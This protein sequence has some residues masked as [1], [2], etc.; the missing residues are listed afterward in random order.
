MSFSVHVDVR[1]PGQFFACCGL[2]ELA[3]RMSEG[4][5]AHFET[6]RFIVEA[7]CSL[8]ELLDGLTGSPLAEVDQEDSTASPIGLPEVFGLRLDWWKDAGGGGR[9]LKVWAGTMQSLRIAQAMVTALREPTFHSENLL[10]VGC[11]VYDPA[12]RTKKVEPFYFD[13]RR[14]PNAHSRDVGFSPNDLGLTTTA[15]PA[16]EALCLVGLQRCRPAPQRDEQRRVFRYSVWQ[17]P[18][19]VT[20]LAAVVSGTVPTRGSRTFE[21][22]NWYRT[23]QRKHK[24]FRYAVPFTKGE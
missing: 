15:F 5:V 14:T 2:F 18:L 16:V 10:D 23:G 6:E 13:A 1:N 7:A 11:V 8:D 9:E 21:F 19:P 4:A 12:D 22:E 3:S 20:L 17:E 24:A